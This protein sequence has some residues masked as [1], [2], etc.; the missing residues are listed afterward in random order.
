MKKRKR[1]QHTSVM[2]ELK[3]SIT[4]LESLPYVERVIFG[5]VECARHAYTPG[6]L[7]FQMDAPG[8]IKIKG[9][10]GTGIMDVYIKVDADHV[11]ELLTKI[12][13]RYE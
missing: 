13:E 11:Q 7:R 8:G 1:G 4:W 10:G 6:H 12:K 2:K 9:Y 3:K 5:R